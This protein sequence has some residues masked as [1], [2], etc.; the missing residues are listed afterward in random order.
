[1]LD[2]PARVSPRPPPDTAHAVSVPRRSLAPADPGRM[3]HH[4]RGLPRRAGGRTVRS[5][6]SSPHLARSGP[7]LAR[8]VAE[9]PPQSGGIGAELVFVLA[10][11][12]ED[13]EGQRPAGGRIVLGVISGSDVEMSM[14]YG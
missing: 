4:S 1:V 9:Q 13:G 5:G 3:P 6:R 14:R 11:V 8:R 2:R 7:G 12:V 10:A